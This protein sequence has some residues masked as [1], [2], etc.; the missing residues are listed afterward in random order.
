MQISSRFTIA[1]HIMIAINTFQE[2][3][4]VTSDFLAGSINVN[5]VIIRRIMQSLKGANL[6]AVK[7]GTGGME[8]AKPLTDITL[9][10][11]FYAVEPLEDG[12]LFHFHENPNPACPVGRNIHAVL[13]DKL[14]AIQKAMEDKMRSITLDA[15]VKDAKNLIKQENL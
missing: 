5:S 7:R 9:L 12:A 10:D 3:Y 2:E 4:K 8:I 11:I 13:E 15:V 14:F 1:T 6:I